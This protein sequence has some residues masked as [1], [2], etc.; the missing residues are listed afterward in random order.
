MIFKYFAIIAF[1]TSLLAGCSTSQRE[2]VRETSLPQPETEIEET[3]EFQGVED[4]LPTPQLLANARTWSPQF[5]ATGFAS[6]IMIEFTG[7][8]KNAE[9]R[10]RYAGIELQPISQDSTGLQL[11]PSITLT[12]T[13]NDLRQA[14]FKVRPGKYLLRQTREWAEQSYVRDI[15]VKEG[16]YSIVS[17]GVK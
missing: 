13:I 5:I 6:G 11:P 7:L 3:T 10:A 8:K 12:T 1:F 16:S 14:F 15:E 9:L 4:S 2:A 17:I